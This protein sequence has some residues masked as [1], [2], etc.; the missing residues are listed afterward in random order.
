MPTA[1]PGVNHADILCYWVSA[2]GNGGP[3]FSPEVLA[4]LARLQ[5]RLGFDIY[6]EG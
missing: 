2:T 4:R 5:L 3:E 1:L 6:F